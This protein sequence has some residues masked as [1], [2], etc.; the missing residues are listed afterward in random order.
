MYRNTVL[1]MAVDT[2][3]STLHEVILNLSLRSLILRFKT[4]QGKETIPLRRTPDSL[5]G[6]HSL[7]FN[8]F[9]DFSQGVKR[10]GRE[11]SHLHVQSRLKM[12]G[13]LTPLPLCLHDVCRNTNLYS[14]VTF[15]ILFVL[16]DILIHRP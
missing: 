13:A 12:S 14:L 2:D 3:C 8:G 6:P 16:Q 15:L 4:R 7:P 10:P 1:H 5:W 9:R 11:P